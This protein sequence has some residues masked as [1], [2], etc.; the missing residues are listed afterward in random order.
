MSTGSH[1]MPVTRLVYISFKLSI[2][3]YK[4]LLIQQIIPSIYLINSLLFLLRRL[5]SL[6]MAV[7]KWS[8]RNGPV[9][10]GN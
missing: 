1:S 3:Q 7:N 2:G 5:N 4:I 6:S 8:G 9:G 10:T